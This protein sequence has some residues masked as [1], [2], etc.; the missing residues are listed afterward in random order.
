MNLRELIDLN[1]GGPGS[2]P[3]PRNA[4]LKG[5]PSTELRERRKSMKDD[6][7]LAKDIDK[8]LWRRSMKG[9]EDDDI[10]CVIVKTKKGY[11]VK[12]EDR[13]KKLGGPYKS[14]GEAQK[15]LQQIE[16]FKNQ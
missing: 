15:R 6:D 14:R 5:I 11:L 2:G 16:Y 1:S 7:E 13:T 3:R 4:S 9:S 10:K 8:E 12:S